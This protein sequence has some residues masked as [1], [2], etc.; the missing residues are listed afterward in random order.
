VKPYQNFQVS[1][2]I[3]GQAYEALRLSFDGNPMLFFPEIA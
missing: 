1:T 3:A 2:S